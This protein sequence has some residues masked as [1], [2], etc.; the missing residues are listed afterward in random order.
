MKVFDFIV[1]GGGIAGLLTAYRLKEYNTLLVDEKGILQG[2]S[3]A[4]GAFLFPKIGIKTSY[5][6]YINSSI[7]EAIK[8]YKNHNINT[9]TKGVLLLPR[10]EKDIE[11]FKNYENEITIPFK[12]M[13][14][15][16]FFDIGSLIEV[17][18]VRKKLKVNF[19]QLNV[20]SLEYKNGVWI[21]NNNLKSKNIILA[22]GHKNIIDIPYINIRPIWGERIEINADNKLDI[23]YHKNCS[24]AYV[25][26]SLR[27][28][29]THKRNCL[30]C[31]ENTNEA[32]ELINK[33]IE[34]IDIKEYEILNIKGGFRAGSIDYFPIIGQ[35]IDTDK[36]ILNNKG[37]VKGKKISEFVYKEGLYI[38]NGMGGRGF[39]NAVSASRILKEIIFENKESVL[40][41]ERLF[42]KWVRKQG[43]KYLKEKLC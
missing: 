38:I 8:F 33:A 32:K 4:A 1:M 18:E 2:A 16:F 40:K 15:G 10:D 21:I 27:I 26:N 9:N 6:E 31:K 34:I 37:I 30:E 24:V 41:S 5:T 43:E 35:I 17:D 11:K 23:Y 39:S 22:T 25:N 20:K 19:Q 7:I 29:A 13:D 28:G 3:S 36:T 14:G 42:T 12:K